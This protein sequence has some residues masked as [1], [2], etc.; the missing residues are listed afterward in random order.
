LANLT[1][2]TEI[3]TAQMRRDA[4]V[5]RIKAEGEA[6]KL[7]TETDA[8]NRSILESARVSQ[9]FPPKLFSRQKNILHYFHRL[10]PMHKLSAPRPKLKPSNSKLKPKQKPS[11]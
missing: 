2:Q 10:K 3:A 9:N 6:I 4:E 8:K 11:Y 5:A 1:G 7:K